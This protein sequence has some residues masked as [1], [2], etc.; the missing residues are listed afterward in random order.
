MPS[1]L[2]Q[3]MAMENN[4]MKHVLALCAL[5]LASAACVPNTQT[6]R[7][8]STQSTAIATPAVSLLNATAIAYHEVVP[9]PA[10]RHVTAHPH[11]R[12]QVSVCSRVIS[13][14]FSST[15]SYPNTMI[16]LKNRAAVVGANALAVTNWI[17]SGSHTY[18]VAHFY[19]CPSKSGL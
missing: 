9:S 4:N 14:A 3:L 7:S 12:L 1:F 11:I 15:H 16:A 2:P 17:E 19:H 18:M 10:S 6:V 5:V 13:I 8:S